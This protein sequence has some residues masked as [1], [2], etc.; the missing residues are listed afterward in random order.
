MSDRRPFGVTL[1]LWMVLTLTAWGAVRLF[2]ALRWWSVLYEFEAR[3]SPL[4]LAIMGAGWVLA[5]GILLWS[6]WS[7]KDWAY[8]AIPISLILWLT[9]YWIERSLFQAGRANL[10]F[11]LG[12]SALLLLLTAVITFSQN[13]RYYFMR[14]EEHEQS[15]QDSTSA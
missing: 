13:T 7:R 14:S 12:A 9:E 5:G 3:L 15:N 2:A 1:L 6:A 11:A 10:T 8:W 4:Y